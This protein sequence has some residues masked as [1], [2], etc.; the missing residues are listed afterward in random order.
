MLTIRFARLSRH[1]LK[2]RRF[3]LL[4][5]LGELAVLCLE[6]LWIGEGY[7]LCNR[8]FKPNMRRLTATECALARSVFGE[9]LPYSKIW[10]DEKAVLGCKK[11]GF[12][13]VSFHIVNS[14]GSITE[15]HLIHELTHVW[16]Y[17]RIGARYMPRALQAQSSRMGYNYGGLPRLQ[18]AAKTC[19]R[20][21]NMEQQA[22][23]V[24]DYFLLT[25][26]KRAQW[27]DAT[28]ADLWIYAPY[29]HELK[30]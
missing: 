28:K 22:D 17:E 10:V 5:W 18:D 8:I 29:I 4:Q 1:F 12:A 24:T 11:G 26:N 6:I 7:V 25:Q 27:S 9:S 20:A 23:I 15:A 16:Q 13:Y 2:I 3:S 19:F 30:S 21:F 14:W